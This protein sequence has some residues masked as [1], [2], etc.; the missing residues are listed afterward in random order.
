MHLRP[1]TLKWGNAIILKRQTTCN[2]V[3]EGS[4]VPEACKQIDEFIIIEVSSKKSVCTY[5]GN[6]GKKLSKS[7]EMILEYG[8]IKPRECYSVLDIPSVGRA[9]SS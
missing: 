1:G 2:Q 9:F 8:L 5:Y 4:R 6:C 3:R 7:L